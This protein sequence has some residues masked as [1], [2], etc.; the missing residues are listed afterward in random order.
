MRTAKAVNKLNGLVVMIKGSGEV[1][2]AIA[3]KLFRCH[4]QICLTELPRPLA[5]SRGATF[6]DA[7]YDGEKEVEGVVAKRI[8][9]F[10]EITSTWRENKIPILVDP[11]ASVNNWLHPEI[12][13]DAI[14]A[15]RNLGTNITD[16]QLVIGVGPGFKAGRDAHMVVETNNSENLGKVILDGTAEEDTGIPIAIGGL[17]TGRVLHSPED[18]LFVA[19]KQ[20]ADKVTTGEVI[21][22][23]SGYPVKAE[24]GGVVR[25]LLRNNIE[26][27]RGLKVGEIDPSGSIKACFSMRAKMRTIAGGVLEAILMHFN[28]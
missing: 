12:L 14:M 19:E 11:E 17:T 27:R 26:V 24:V 18:G 6:S 16:A 10:A 23:V 2:S 25:A 20:I 3:H 22:S 15:K 28:L 4:F 7:V 21:A 1:A 9:S 13:I 8:D 5:I